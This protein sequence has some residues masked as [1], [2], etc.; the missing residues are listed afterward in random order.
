MKKK[1]KKK[2]NELETIEEIPALK[3]QNLNG[4]IINLDNIEEK[5]EDNFDD[6][7]LDE[8]NENKEDCGKTIVYS[9]GAQ[10]WKNAT[11]IKNNAVEN[12]DESKAFNKNMK[13]E[14]LRRF[15]F[16]NIFNFWKN[17][18]KP[19]EKENEKEK[20]KAAQEKWKYFRKYLEKINGVYLMQIIASI[21]RAK[22]ILLNKIPVP[23]AK[24]FQLYQIM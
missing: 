2:K 1:K 7:E 11:S 18:S 6:E 17:D 19:K 5:N 12:D 22:Y 15:H 16:R 23:L 9:D 3:I 14:K 10:F 21:T 20:I 4:Q 13:S 24:K 8:D